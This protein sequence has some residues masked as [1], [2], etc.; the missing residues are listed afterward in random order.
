MTTMLPRSKEQESEFSLCQRAETL[1]TQCLLRA[2]SDDLLIWS[3][4]DSE[5]KL[6][7]SETKRADSETKQTDS[8]TKKRGFGNEDSKRKQ[9]IRKP[10]TG[11]GNA[12]SETSIWKP[13]ARIPKPGFGNSKRG[14]GNRTR[15][16]GNWTRRF[17]SHDSETGRPDSATGHT[18]LETRIRKLDGRLYWSGRLALGRLQILV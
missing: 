13:Y 2:L 16:F 18:V 17:G 11:C 10:K 1:P 4:A 14:F 7:D 3:A 9:R 5:T 12:D 15:G 6:T 8:E